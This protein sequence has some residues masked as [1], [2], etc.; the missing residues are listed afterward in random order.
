MLLTSLDKIILL[1]CFFLVVSLYWVLWRVDE[2]AHEVEIIVGGEKTYILDLHEDKRLSVKG[3]QG[4][5][6]IEIKNG[7]AR[8]I[9]SSCNTSF[10]VRSGWQSHSGDFIACLPN[11]VSIHL[12][13]GKKVYDAINF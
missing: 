13:G 4:E 2:E 7:Q 10:C 1:L 6:I 5:S 3:K 9:S 12:A 8:F 11:S